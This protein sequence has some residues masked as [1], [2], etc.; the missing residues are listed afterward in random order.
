MATQTILI[1]DFTDPRFRTAFQTYFIEL[2]A[3]IK[4]WDGLFREM[5]EDG[6]NSAYLAL[7]ASDTAIGFLQFQLTAF[8]NWFMEEKLGFIR[9]FWVDP[10]HRG[11]GLGT[12]LLS[13]TERYLKEHSAYRAVLTSDNAIGFYLARG[14]IKS[15]GISAKNKMEVLSKDLSPRVQ[16]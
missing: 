16:S 15:P 8:T 6:N 9:E 10:A 1:S 14:Y 7:D 13:M 11:R 4:D 5:N 3:H 2:G 12:E